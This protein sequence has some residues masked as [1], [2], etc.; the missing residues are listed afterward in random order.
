MRTRQMIMMLGLMVAT[1]VMAQDATAPAP[2]PA[3][4]T[5]AEAPAPAPAPAADVAA[6]APSEKAKGKKAKGEAAL[7]AVPLPARK[8]KANVPSPVL[9]AKRVPLEEWRPEQCPKPTKA[10]EI[11]VCGRPE[12]PAPPPPAE[13]VVPG[14]RDDVAS[15]REALVAPVRTGDGSCSAV[16]PNGGMGC[17]AEAAR[18]WKRDKAAAKAAKRAEDRKID[19]K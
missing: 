15:E 9:N 8:G 12:E 5:Q 2:A 4:Q 6:P 14:S 17:G 16:G 18:Q 7:P 11:V 1:P 19:Q 13:P 3:P 10:G